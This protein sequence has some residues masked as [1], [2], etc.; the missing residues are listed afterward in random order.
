MSHSLF[1][2][3]L[4]TQDKHFECAQDDSILEAGL[5]HGLSMRYECSNGTCGACRAKLTQGTI[6]PI[7]HHDYALSQ[8]AQDQGEFLTC[9]YAPESDVSLDIELIGDVRSI[10][11]Q[12]IETKVKQVQLL[13]DMAILTL[14]TPRSKTLQ[15]M[16]GQD[17][18]LSYQGLSSRYPIASCPCQGM[19]LE[20]HIR[21][22]QED[23][24]SQAI[25]Q[26]NIKSKTKI[27][28][29]GPRGVF[30]LNETSTRPMVF[31]AW[32]GGFAPI[33]SLIEHAFSL[34]MT[35][36]VQLYWA[37]PEAEDKPYFDNHAQAWHQVLDEY[38]YHAIGCQ[39]DRSNQNDCHQVA[40]QILQAL[41]LDLIKR[42]QVYIA[43][44][45]ELLI[46]LSELLLKEG[47][48]ETQLIGSPT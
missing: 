45:A 3:H 39:F 16:A 40:K 5:R 32:D 15:F 2:V 22:L 44:P 20:F 41:D 26:R 14:R 12:Q 21:H 24:F 18:V 6:K 35:Q 25:F 4:N 1:N 42:A 31:I 17:V 48:N 36:A 43:A 11:Q 47:L 38:H 8:E 13:G 28:L 10:P 23:A 27:D 46:Y 33:R 37:Y 34:E 7:K 29:N 9:C 19:E 30:V